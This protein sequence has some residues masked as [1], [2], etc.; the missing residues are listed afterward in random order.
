LKS[1]HSHPATP[2]GSALWLIHEK[3]ES[4]ETGTEKVNGKKGSGSGGPPDL[5]PFIQGL[6]KE[7][8]PSGDIWPEAKRQLW[9]D[10]ASSIFKIIYEDDVAAN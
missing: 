2:S 8:P 10:T 3:Y 9:L 1:S 6:L 5:H 4:S 7:L